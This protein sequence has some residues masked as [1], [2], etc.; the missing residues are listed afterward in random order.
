M[1]NPRKLPPSAVRRRMNR[2]DGLW[3][4]I[5]DRKP[6]VNLETGRRGTV[7]RRLDNLPTGY[8]LYL[9]RYDDG[10]ERRAL[11]AL[12]DRSDTPR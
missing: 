12:L 2:A 9:I 7:L 10:I 6:V 3:K 8:A 5:P 1:I 11:R 4:N